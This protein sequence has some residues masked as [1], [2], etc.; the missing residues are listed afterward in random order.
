VS[1]LDDYRRAQRLLRREFDA[2]TDRLCPQCPEP[3]CRVP[4]RVTALDIVIAEAAGWTARLPTD[5]TT[6]AIRQ[7]EATFKGGEYEP[8]SP[9]PFLGERGCSMPP[10]LR[11]LECTA[12]VCRFISA[13]TDARGRA[14]LRRLTAEMRRAH[15]RLIPSGRRPGAM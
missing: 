5:A 2:V 10:D 11:P 1:A 13:A 7:A 3:C 6:V 12:Y 14:R 9:C 4:A 15:V 8:G